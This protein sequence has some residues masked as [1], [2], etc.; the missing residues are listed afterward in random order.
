MTGLQNINWV[1]PKDYSHHAVEPSF[2]NCASLFTPLNQPFS[3]HFS[4]LK[5]FQRFMNVSFQNKIKKHEDELS[6]NEQ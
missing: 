2:G 5:Y 4:Q 6:V 1:E 3:S